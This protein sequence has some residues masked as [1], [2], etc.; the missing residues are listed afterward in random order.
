MTARQSAR[1]QMIPIDK[2]TVVNPRSRGKIKFK[3]IVANIAKIG[4]KRPITVA[5]RPSPGGEAQYDLVCGQGRLEAF[6]A[7]GQKTVPALIVDV[8]KEDCL[9]MSLAENLAR[10]K[11]NCVEMMKQIGALKERGY[12]LTEIAEKTDLEVAFVRGVIRLLKNGEERLLQAVE[13]G[14]IPMSVAVTIASSDDDEVQLALADAYKNNTLRG[15][16]LLHARRLIEK[17]RTSGKSLH[18]RERPR[19]PRGALSSASILR[20]YQR[21][22]SRQ[23]IILQKARICET[24]LLFIT[25]ALKKLLADEGFVNLLRAEKLET[26]PQQLAERISGKGD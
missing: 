14:T 2:I 8:P 7:L 1:V 6:Q 21:E 25:S 12:T 16:A 19:R 17:R 18:G 24:R 26:L 20:A 13:Q 22:T 15:K 3:Q 4:L 23:K 5:Q 10:R 11:Y 9:L